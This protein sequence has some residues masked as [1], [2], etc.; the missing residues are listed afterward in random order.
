MVQAHSGKRLS[1][2]TAS[3]RLAEAFPGERFLAGN[4]SRHRVVDLA[5]QALVQATGDRRFAA[6][7]SV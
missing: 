7:A 1:R 2:S 4:A 3:R 5:R 6:D